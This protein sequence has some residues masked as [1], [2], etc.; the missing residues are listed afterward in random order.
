MHTQHTPHNAHTFLFFPSIFLAISLFIHRTS[1][2]FVVRGHS[3]LL[4]GSSNPT[5]HYVTGR[6]LYRARAYTYKHLLSSV[7]YRILTPSCTYL[8]ILFSLYYFTYSSMFLEGLLNLKG[9]PITQSR[10]YTNI[11]FF[12]GNNDFLGY[13]KYKKLLSISNLN[14][15]AIKVIRSAITNYCIFRKTD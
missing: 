15:V 13:C 10:I 1:L 7:N 14:Y 4:P 8:Y 12:Y 6:A 11:F 2:L 3:V 5:A 9:L